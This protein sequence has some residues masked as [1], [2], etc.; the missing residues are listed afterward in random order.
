MISQVTTTVTASKNGSTKA[1]SGSGRKIISDA[2]IPF[3]PA[4]DEPSNIL[5]SSITSS[6]TLCAGKLMCCSLPRVSVKRK[7]THFAFE[8]L[9][10]SNNLFDMNSLRWGCQDLVINIYY[11]F[12]HSN[13]V[14]KSRCLYRD[15]Y[16]TSYYNKLCYIL[17][18]FMYKYTKVLF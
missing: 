9:I 11:R 15:T 8:D 4:M 1:V 12:W 2:S 18:C 16:L 5:P 7:S 17:N 13:L 3:Q 6:S 14:L 10:R